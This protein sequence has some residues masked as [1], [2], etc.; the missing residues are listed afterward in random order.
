MARGV[1]CS[2]PGTL[3]LVSHGRARRTAPPSGVYQ[4]RRLP[5]DSGILIVASVKAE[6]ARPKNSWLQREA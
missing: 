6:K 4:L 2:E 3:V 1:I 5:Q